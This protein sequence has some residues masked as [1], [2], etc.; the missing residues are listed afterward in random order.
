[1]KKKQKN[2]VALRFLWLIVAFL[3]VLAA[4]L[5]VQKFAPLEQVEVPSSSHGTTDL[6]TT[7]SESLFPS[8]DLSSD[9]PEPE[10]EPVPDTDPAMEQALAATLFAD[11]IFSAEHLAVYDRTAGILLYEKNAHESITAAST[12]KLLTALV[13]L[14][15]VEE[16]TVFTVGT[17]LSLVG[18]GSSTAGL[19]KGYVLTVEQALDALL[20]PSGNDAAYVIAAHV[21]RNLARDDQISDREAVEYFLMRMNER[22]KALGATESLFTCPDGYPDG[23]QYTTAF[24][25]MQI[26]LAAAGNPTIRKSVSKTYAAY[27]MNDGTELEFTTTNQLLLPSSSYYYE[28]SFGMKTG[29]TPAAGQCMISGA[30]AYGHEVVVALFKAPDNPSRWKDSRKAL[31]VASEAIKQAQEAYSLP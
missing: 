8:S 30:V 11:A 5:S 2:S 28:G 26:A 6:P 7:D 23:K 9:E 27:E 19:K 4:L 31:D 3:L 22:A 14:E 13:M 12:T 24:D 21:G 20:I 15:H 1:M 17:E 29:S 10:P 16:D 25:M 18:R